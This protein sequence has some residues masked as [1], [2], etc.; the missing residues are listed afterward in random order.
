MKQVAAILLALGLWATMASASEFPA[1]YRV[2]GVAGNDVLNVRALPSADAGIVGDYGA[3][4]A[5][6]EVTG[7]SEDGKWLRVNTDEGLGW[8]A[9][10]FLE[11][12]GEDGDYLISRTL[13][14]FGTEPFWS[15]D[16]IQG[17]RATFSLMSEE[18]QVFGA[19]LMRRAAGRTDRYL[20]GFG[21]GAAV[22]SRAECGDGMSD[23]AYA[24]DASV[25]LVGESLTLYAG[26]CSIEPD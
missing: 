12:E 11:P 8:V 9:A 13:N 17:A 22:V 18:P 26:C 4:Q 16:V 15:L 20:L 7:Q 19:G 2:T 21:Q 25:L 14:C 1:L 5:G 10:R 23:R 24:L 6:V 3:Q